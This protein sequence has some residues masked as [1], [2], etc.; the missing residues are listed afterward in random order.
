[1]ALGARL[2]P[3]RFLGP[4]GLYWLGGEMI[5]NRARRADSVAFWVNSV[6]SRGPGRLVGRAR[7]TF[8][9]LAYDCPGEGLF[10][11]L[12]RNV[13]LAAGGPIFGEIDL[14]FM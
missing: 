12:G 10:S 4:A 5:E 9:V 3:G 7:L 8:G 2:A 13:T 11:G 14:K 6:S 1:M